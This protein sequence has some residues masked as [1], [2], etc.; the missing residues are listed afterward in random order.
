M[1]RGLGNNPEWVRP[2]QSGDDDLNATISR[3]IT[4]AIL[5][6]DGE[7]APERAKATEYYQGQPFGNEQDGRSKAILTEVRDGIIGVEPSIIRIVHGP[8]R[9]VEYV[10]N[11]AA[12]V[13]MAEQ[14]TDYASWIYKEDNSGLLVTKS[15]LRDGLLKKLGVGKVGMD[16]TPKATTTLYRGLTREQ[17]G[18][19]LQGSGTEPVRITPV[20]EDAFDAE[21]RTTEPSARI[22]VTPVPPDDFF[23]NREARSLDDAIIVGHRLRLTR[24]ELRRMGVSDEDLDEYGGTL[25][26]GDETIEEVARRQNA[27]ASGL[28]S[29]AEMGE[30]NRRILYCE[31]YMMLDVDG[32]GITELRKVCT[33]GDAHRP[34][35]N[36]P[37][38]YKPFAVFS[39][40]PEPHA[41]LG[42]SWY[43]RLKDVQEI[44][45]QLL[46][47]LFDSL[48][49]SV[50]PRPTYVEGQV[51][52]ADLMNN[53]VGTPVRQKQ[54]GMVEWQVIPFAGDKILPVLGSMR[55]VVERR[56]GNQQGAGSLDLDALQSTGKEAADAAI[57]AAQAQPELLAWL[58]AEQ[59][60]KPVFR[61]ILKLVA[62]PKSRERLIRLRGVYVPVNPAMFDPNM[63]VSVNVCLGAMDSAKKVA[64]LRD[65]VADQSAILDKFGPD[66]PVVSIQMLRNSKAKLL[67]L[68]GIKDVE[69]YYKSIPDDWQPPPPAPPEPTPDE[70]WI[71]AEK[72]MAFQKQM[73]ELAIKQDEL[74]LKEKQQEADIAFR[75]AELAFRE[76][77]AF[78]SLEMER[79]RLELEAEKIAVSREQ[80]AV[81]REQAEKAE[82]KETE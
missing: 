56:I 24:S 28:S 13:A 63:D 14:A 40:D 44:N 19:V 10:P 36:E 75:E 81:Q 60:L 9:P 17:I 20:G 38:A 35:K 71:Q 51:S 72:E 49:I 61:I 66:N 47:G 41:M 25:G 43:D 79:A 39:P 4:D 58:F 42:G 23:W 27:N 52:L 45:S 21:I 67:E 18:L 82:P 59:F 1:D 8:E 70:M 57:T 69:A 76:R 46:R 31:V 6:I 73:K 26:V 30:A 50:F 34:V 29:D 37:A 32:S 5:Y 12:D 15:V 78:A 53:G 16:E 65:V 48:A 3:A 62:H 2:D 7:I 68:Q 77:E 22:W 54:A 80:V 74:A 55:E 33:L 64:I 11:A